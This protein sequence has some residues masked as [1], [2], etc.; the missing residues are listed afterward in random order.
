MN[1]FKPNVTSLHVQEKP[2]TMQFCDS[3]LQT[4]NVKSQITISRSFSSLSLLLPVIM[5][6]SMWITRVPHGQTQGILTFEIFFCQSPHPHLHILCHN[7]PLSST[8][9]G[10]NAPG[11]EHHCHNPLGGMSESCQ[12]PL[13][14]HT[15]YA[16]IAGWYIH[17]SVPTIKV[18]YIYVGSCLDSW[19]VHSTIAR[20]HQ[21]EAGCLVLKLCDVNHLKKKHNNK[22]IIIKTTQVQYI[23]LR[24]IH[25]CQC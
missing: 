18:R 11:S 5:H 3:Q 4:T 19:S 12:N 6:Q 14:I 8:P 13:G 9:G 2:W 1:I 24:V 10:G 7:P 22:K 15:D 25:N 21:G 17:E 16:L 23:Y 20:L